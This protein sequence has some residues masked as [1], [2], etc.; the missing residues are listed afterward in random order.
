MLN[1]NSAG[2]E[3][4]AVYIEPRDTVLTEGDVKKNNRSLGRSVG[5]SPSGAVDVQYSS[6]MTTIRI[7]GTPVTK[8]RQLFEGDCF[9]PYAQNRQKNCYSVKVKILEFIL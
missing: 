7:A 2:T 9:L 3:N 6:G 1:F 5:R 4:P 8:R